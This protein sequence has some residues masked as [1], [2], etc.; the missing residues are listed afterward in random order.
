MPAQN[1]ISLFQ[2]RSKGNPAP[3]PFDVT[4]NFHPDRMT[5]D[6]QPLLLA[7]ARDGCLKSQFETGTSNGGLS[8]FVGGDRWYWESRVF[9]GV[10]D[11]SEPPQRPK[12]GALNINDFEFGA[13]PRFGSSHFRLKPSVLARTTLCYPDS[14]YQPKDFATPEYAQS[15]IQLLE[16]DD[17][18]PLDAYIEAQI[19]DVIDL[20]KDIDALVL[21]P[22]FKGTEIEIFA[23]N[24]PVKTEW[25]RGFALDLRCFALPEN[26]RGQHIVALASEIAQDRLL[27]PRII[28]AA[29]QSDNHDPQDIKKVWHYLARFG[30]QQTHLS[31]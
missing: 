22:S 3:C 6:N 27:T 19:H 20:E 28:G 12:Y 31:T 11:E 8:A 14:Y 30:Y 18:E 16:S 10:Y 4:I 26:Y 13:S 24:L 9:D 2:R 15:L 23:S 21:D 1:A 29:L 17:V 7:I 5:S 25:H